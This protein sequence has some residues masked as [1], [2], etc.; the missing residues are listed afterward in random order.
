MRLF[1][2]NLSVHFCVVQCLFYKSIYGPSS[3]GF[4]SLQVVK[5]FIHEQTALQAQQIK[6]PLLSVKTPFLYSKFWSVE[7]S[8]LSHVFN[9]GQQTRILPAVTRPT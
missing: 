2:F 9:I 7:S 5:P 1:A 3:C 4:H 6:P 8:V